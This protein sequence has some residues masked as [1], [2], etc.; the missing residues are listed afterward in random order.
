MWYLL[1][2]SKNVASGI[3]AVQ[4]ATYTDD[5]NDERNEDIDFWYLA[6]N[7]DLSFYGYHEGGIGDERFPAQDVIL[8]DPILFGQEDM[9]TGTVI[10]DSGT[11]SI[12]VILPI[13]GEVTR[14]ITIN[15]RVEYVE[16]MPEVF[17]NMSPVTPFK[18]VLLVTV[19]MAM[20]L[21]GLGSLP[22]RK[23]TFYLKR[24]IG[25]IVQNQTADPNDAEKQAIDS[26]QV[27]GMD[28]AP[29]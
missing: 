8:T 17:T 29:H 9:T 14:T 18:D 26:G 15:S 25:M 7:G 24:N 4:I 19:D 2:E 28:F 12:R 20:E 6:P 1:E 13:I 3:D 16:F 11:G 21:P 5:P 23:N 27:G 10:T 22:L